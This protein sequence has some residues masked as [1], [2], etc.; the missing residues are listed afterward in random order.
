MKIKI[1][2]IDN[3][4]VLVVD[5]R[6]N[7]NSSKLI[8]TTGAL[9]DKGISKIV[10]D[11]RY[12]NFIDYNGLSV[13]AI[14]YKNALSCNANMKLCG[15][16]SNI[17]EL[18]KVVK[19]DDV[20]EIYQGLDEALES[21]K[22]KTKHRASGHIKEHLR[23]KFSRLDL[24]MPVIYRL[25]KSI[26]RYKTSQPYSGRMENLSGAGLFVRAINLMPAGSNVFIE[27]MLDKSKGY[28]RL[29][30]IVL[31]IADKALQPKLYPGM[32]IGFVSISKASQEEILSFIDKHAI[33]R[34]Q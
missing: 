1:N 22:S 25:S 30:G 5:G 16:S 34:R 19:L 14:T 21:F 17:Y 6:I 11:M 7:I 8:D 18:L 24:D 3:V 31:W 27:L 2:Y 12:V 23:R 10:I 15:I 26:G 20:F 32:G 4:A 33:C 28:K 9:I 13:L 29:N